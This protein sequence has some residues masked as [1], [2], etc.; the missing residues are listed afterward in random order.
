LNGW[1][2]EHGARSTRWWWLI[3]FHASLQRLYVL[4]LSGGSSGVEMFV[5]NTQGRRVVPTAQPPIN[6][7]KE[8]GGVAALGP[9]SYRCSRN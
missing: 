9:I 8:N 2:K 3:E 5:V 7:L 6:I 1:V 4:T